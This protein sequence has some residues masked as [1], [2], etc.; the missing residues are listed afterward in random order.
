MSTEKKSCTAETGKLEKIIFEMY[1][2]NTVIEWLPNFKKTICI[3]FFISECKNAFFLPA[4]LEK[5]CTFLL[6]KKTAVIK[7]A[8]LQRSK[9]VGKGDFS[10]NF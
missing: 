7:L 3:Q 8:R 5:W 2:N 6:T 9:R 1:Q 10:G 4:P